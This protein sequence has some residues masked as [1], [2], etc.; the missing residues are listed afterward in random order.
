MKALRVQKLIRQQPDYCNMAALMI[1]ITVIGKRRSERENRME[2]G[3][4]KENERNSWVQLHGGIASMW[5]T[6]CSINFGF[7]FEKNKKF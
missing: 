4:R 1:S 6:V 3:G 5:F 7:D 2:S